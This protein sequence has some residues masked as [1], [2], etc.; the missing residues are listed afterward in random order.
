MTDN[1]SIKSLI[2]PF[3]EQLF[4]LNDKN[5]LLTGGT[6]S[7]GQAFTRFVLDNYKPKRLIIF[8]RDELKQYEMQILPTF[9]NKNCLRFF[10]GDIRDKERLDLAMRDVDIVI[11]AAALKRIE[12]AEYNP[13]ECIKTNVLGSQNIV[14]CAIKN[15]VKKVIALS[16]DKATNPANLYGASKLAS[17]KL[18]VAANN[19]SGP[20]STRFASV[21]Y[22]NVLGSRGSVLQIFRDCINRKEDKLPI[23]DKRMTR[24]WISLEKGV[25]FVI[26]CL[27]I[28]SGGEIFVPKLPSSK[29]IDLALAL[30]SKKQLKFIGKKP[31][32]KLHEILISEDEAFSTL[33]IGDRYV[34]EPAFKWWQNTDKK[35]YKG[36]KV[37]EDFIYSSGNNENLFEKKQM[38]SFLKLIDV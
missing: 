21:R 22:G 23:T 20:V 1:K 34:V 30:D 24:F 36:K 27:K 7:F 26:S 29:V 5:I 8:S 12:V 31:G 25:S 18:F 2:T 6:G 28:M 15:K 11:H 17:E 35:L 38:E 19:L 16:T 4:N 9:K 13:F 37:S 14:D 10:I 33:D 3:S 32:E